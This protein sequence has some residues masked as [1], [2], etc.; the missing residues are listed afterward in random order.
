VLILT[1]IRSKKFSYSAVIYDHVLN[2]L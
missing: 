1:E 2:S